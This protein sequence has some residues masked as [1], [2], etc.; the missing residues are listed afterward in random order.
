M[1][2]SLNAFDNSCIALFV[3]N[4]HYS[5]LFSGMGFPLIAVDNSIILP[6]TRKGNGG[7]GFQLGHSERKE[8]YFR[9]KIDFN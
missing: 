3:C 1:N 6:F 7:G 2:Q 4:I 9:R 5:V 8:D